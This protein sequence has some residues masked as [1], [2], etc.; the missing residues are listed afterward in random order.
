MGLVNSALELAWCYVKIAK[1]RVKSAGL[2]LTFVSHLTSLNHFLNLEHDSTE[3]D[4]FKVAI[5]SLKMF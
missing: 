1:G 5:S 2:H 3:L 4:S